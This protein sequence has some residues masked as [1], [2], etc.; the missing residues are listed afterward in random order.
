LEIAKKL[1]MML[2]LRVDR[3]ADGKPLSMERMEKIVAR[4]MKKTDNLFNQNWFYDWLG[5]GNARG[6]FSD[7]TP[8]AG[9]ALVSKQVL[10][11]SLNRNYL[12]QSAAI[13]HT[14]EETFFDS[15]D[16]PTEYE[17]AFAEFQSYKE[18][19][20]GRKN[21]DKKTTWIC[22]G[23]RINQLTR[24]TVTEAVYDLVMYFQCNQKPLLR[25]ARYSDIQTEIWLSSVSGADIRGTR[26]GIV[27]LAPSHSSINHDL[28]FV[29]ENIPPSRKFERLGALLSLRAF[30]KN[31]RGKENKKLYSG[32]DQK[33][34]VRLE[35][36]R[37]RVDDFRKKNPNEWLSPTM[38]ELLNEFNFPRLKQIFQRLARRCN[39][40]EREFNF[41]D[42]DRI[43]DMARPGWGLPAAYYSL[44][45]NVVGLLPPF[46]YSMIA[47]ALRRYFPDPEEDL[48]ID[49]DTLCRIC[50]LKSLIHEEIHAL[51]R[52]DF[53]DLV[54]ESMKDAF[55]DRLY[56]D[57]SFGKERGGFRTLIQEDEKIEVLYE[58]FD[59]GVTEKLALQ[60]LAEYLRG[61]DLLDRK[62]VERFL[63]KLPEFEGD[64]EVIDYVFERN[65]IDEVVATA[66]H[67]S[68]YS[69]KEIW[70][71]IIRSK[72]DR[73]DMADS[74]LDAFFDENIFEKFGEKMK[75]LRARC[76]PPKGLLAGIK[77]ERKE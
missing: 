63:E 11:D 19:L 74:I 67:K 44:E 71:A 40:P 22:S 50:I 59:E 24:Q 18:S 51:S 37:N 69:K 60:V 8:R 12:D 62:T 41:C 3:T 29:I 26:F 39:L 16:V 25:D 23:L 5:S 17:E 1:G 73:T 33:G 6:I 66:A 38:R 14:L 43:T 75:E 27:A 64:P 2:V 52:Q 45:E 36:I 76:R 15:S 4:K 21:S 70:A 68:G 13:I 54:P 35:R 49:K 47:G 48:E 7:E 72:V 65:L 55:S 34:A 42:K 20:A 31:K 61:D 9:W 32:V 77:R 58:A 53:S 28:N 46:L 10:P 30:E 56:E 57:A